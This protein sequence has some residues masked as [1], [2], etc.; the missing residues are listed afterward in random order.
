MRPATPDHDTPGAPLPTTLRHIASRLAANTGWLLGG[1]GF[2]AVAS[3]GYLALASRALGL[4]R[5]GVFSLILA[6]GGTIAALAQFKSWQAV[7]RY[8]ALHLADG[9]PDRLARLVGFTATVDWLSALAGIVLAAVAVPLVA[10]LLGWTAEQQW[11]AALLAAVLLATTG[12][13]ASGVLRLFNRYDLL[14]AAEAVGPTV[15]LIG[16]AAAWRAGGGLA[17][18]LAIWGLAAALETG[19]QWIAVL[20][21]RRT[22]ITFGRTAFRAALSENPRVGPFMVQNSLAGSLGLLGERAGTLVVG[23]VGGPVV[24]GGFRVAAKLAGGVGKLADTVTRALFPELVRLAASDDRAVLRQVAWRTTTV[25]CLIALA[26]V[27]FVWMAGPA[28]LALV[29]GQH[30]DVA[31]PYLL[32]LT[33]AAAVDLIGL[34]F[35]PILNA[36]GRSGRVLGARVFGAVAYLATLAVLLPIVGTMAAASAAVAMAVAIRATL[37][38]ACARLLGSEDGERTKDLTAAGPP[39]PLPETDT[40]PT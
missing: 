3:I 29:F 4:E 27:G 13:T 15:R 38:I 36:H 12:A 8:G 11:D 40:K 9:R 16:A 5:F 10:P 24:A 6:Y 17:A 33:I 21:L 25:A 18:F 2:N 37:A 28:L 20:R 19:A 32:L 7:I 23:A 30:L 34:A 31:Q 26:L 22:R 14:S 39:R 1:R 35:E